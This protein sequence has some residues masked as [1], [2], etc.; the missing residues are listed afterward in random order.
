MK[1]KRASDHGSP[2]RSSA[3]EMQKAEQSSEE[4]QIEKPAQ[5][6]TGLTAKQAQTRVVLVRKPDGPRNQ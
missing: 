2:K 6:L 4:G 1:E 3:T 5:T